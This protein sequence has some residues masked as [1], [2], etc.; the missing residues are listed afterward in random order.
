MST[1]PQVPGLT[2]DQV[3]VSDVAQWK[4]FLRKALADTRVAT[5]AFLTADMDAVHQTVTVQIAIQERVRFNGQQ[6]WWDVP[7]IINVPILVPRGGGFS[8]TLPLKKGDQGMLIFCDTCFDN[9]WV[10]GQ[11]AAPP[12]QNSPALP[13]PNPSGS[14]RQLEVR[15]HHI[16]DCGFLPGMWSQN[17]L[18]TDYSTDSLQIR[19]DDGNTVI[20]V[21]EAGVTISGAAVMAQNDGPALALVN[22]T[23]FQFWLTE[24]IPFLVAKGFTGTT[25]LGSETTILKGQ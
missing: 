25:P 18:L 19:S 8:V 20:D 23:F 13:G 4:L 5:P 24:V 15:R 17:N 10:N 2:L 7:P 21:A 12:V 22:D 9:W 14:Q 3:V 11:T 16:H 6:Q 1:T